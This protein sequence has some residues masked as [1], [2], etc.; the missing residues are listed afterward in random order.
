MPSAQHETPVAVIRTNPDLLA[1]L[2][3]FEFER[4]VPDFEHVRPHATDVRVMVPRT[5]HADG[6]VVFCDAADAAGD[7]H[8]MGGVHVHRS[9]LRV[10]K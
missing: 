1:W 9:R 3:G 2:L 5:Y 4:K 10:S 7:P 6:M 8:P